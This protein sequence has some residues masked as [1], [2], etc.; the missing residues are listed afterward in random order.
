VKDPQHV[1]IIM[2]GNG[3]WAQER[4]H[5]RVYGHVRGAKVARNIIEGSAQRG[6]KFLT[7]FTF[8]TENWGRPASEVAILMLLLRRQLKRELQ[9]LLTNN[10]K[11]RVIGNLSSLPEEV[12]KVVE[13]TVAATAHCAGMTL[14]FAL[15]YGGRQEL[16]EAMQKIA[17]R[18]AMGNITP[19][20]VSEECIAESLESAFLP[21][22]DLIIR[23]SGEYRLSNFFLW[24]AAYSEIYITDKLWPDFTIADLEE[25]I[26]AFA[27]R[28]RRFGRIEVAP[29]ALE[30]I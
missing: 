29:K 9:T 21:D 25:A 1:A 28:E 26:N 4:Q 8:S 17:R 18:V 20:Q 2:D 7:L 30:S 14:T 15:S 16:K 11:F 13:E 23:S 5:S 22:P 24:Q 19:A 6:I 3:R 27:S 10:I 12:L